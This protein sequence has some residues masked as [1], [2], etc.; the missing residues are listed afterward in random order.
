[1]QTSLHWIHA[2]NGSVPPGA[3]E[4][5]RTRSGEM[6]YVG[7]ANYQNTLTLGKVHPSHGCLYIPYDGKEIAIK[8][9]EV[10]VSQ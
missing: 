4:S 1:M 10:L 5:G 6:L 2:S 8:H 3:V 7:R 9:Y